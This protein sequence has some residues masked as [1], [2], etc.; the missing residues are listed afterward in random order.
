MEIVIIK[1]FALYSLHLH[2]SNSNYKHGHCYNVK[3]TKLSV[4]SYPTLVTNDFKKKAIS[5]PSEA[6][7][8][9]K[10]LILNKCF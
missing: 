6:L 1:R 9:G 10:E 2:I 7:L 4:V 5:Q 3:N 8:S